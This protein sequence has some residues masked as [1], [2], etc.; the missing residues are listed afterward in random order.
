MSHRD[1]E[2]AEEYRVLLMGT[3]A[4]LR[5]IRKRLLEVGMRPTFD[6]V[7]W[8]DIGLRDIC[9]V[10]GEQGDDDRA[11]PDIMALQGEDQWLA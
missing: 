1:Y 5:A 2:R 9:R 7:V 3:E 6:A 10:L 11:D 8:C 4:N